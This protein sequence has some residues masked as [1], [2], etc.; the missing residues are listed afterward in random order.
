MFGPGKSQSVEFRNSVTK[1]SVIG[2]ELYEAVDLFPSHEFQIP[3][4]ARPADA[5]SPFL[6]YIE[7]KLWFISLFFTGSE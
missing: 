2:S 5:S 4:I 7:M 3:Q 6:N 1:E